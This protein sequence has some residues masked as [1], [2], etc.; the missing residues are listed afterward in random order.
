VRNGSV[1]NLGTITQPL[2][3]SV[4]NL[5]FWNATTVNG[6]PF[7]NNNFGYPHLGFTNPK[8]YTPFDAVY[9]HLNANDP[10]INN[11]GLGTGNFIFS[12]V[13]PYDLKLQNRT[14][15]STAPYCAAFEARY[16]ITA[17]SNVTWTTPY[18]D[19]IVGAQGDVDFRAGQ[20]IQLQPGFQT[21]YGSMFSALIQPYTCP[22]KV[23]ET[24]SPHV[25][26]P[27][28][29]QEHSVMPEEERLQVPAGN[30][31]PNPGTGIYNLQL[32]TGEGVNGMDITD[33]LGRKLSAYYWNLA[34]GMLTLHI[35][36]LQNGVYLVTVHLKNGEH[37]S[38]KIIKE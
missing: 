10:H 20:Y 32:T 15:G 31:Y 16:T 12:E 36:D 6:V 30:F 18:V 27:Y 7:I 5:L 35:E 1:G 2:T 34:L 28:E 29:E 22:P 17:G 9:A 19:Y 3:L 4:K 25:N 21:V 14:I 37:I 8:L 11:P 24:S 33:M 13:A 38:T 23:L 26:L